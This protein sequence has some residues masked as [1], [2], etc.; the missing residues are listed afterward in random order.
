[1]THVKTVESFARL[2]GFCSGYGGYN[3][4]RQSL[5]VD[6]LTTQ[7][8]HIQSAI[9]NVK[10]AKAEYDNEVNQRKQ[11]FDQ[12]PRLLSGILRRLE[13]SGAKPEKLEDARAYVHQIIGAS[14]KNREPLPSA[15]AEG[16]PV[17]RGKLQLAYV[18]KAD[19][20]S[21][22]VKAVISE[23]LYQP[24]ENQFTQAG[25]E[26]K[27]TELNQLN[28]HVADA[29]RKWSEALIDR[30]K[31]LYKD[32]GSMTQSARAVKKYVRGLFGH[33]SAEY[34]LIKALE[35]KKPGKS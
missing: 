33:D 15:Q 28:R 20:F 27:V 24:R 6:A 18:S 4:G 19:S 1:M 7:L 5:Q 29:R 14:P 3:P 9:E 26:E 34:A 8:N 13:A 31:V 22:L 16:K 23:P 2:L 25:L 21:K 17:Q 11:A 10:I 35:F 32:E 12:L 30:N